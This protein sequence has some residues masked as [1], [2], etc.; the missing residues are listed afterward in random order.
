MKLEYTNWE[1]Y[2]ELCNLYTKVVE[3]QMVPEISLMYIVHILM[4][5][6]VVDN[7]LGRHHLQLQNGQGVPVPA[8]RT[9]CEQTIVMRSIFPI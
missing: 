1:T 6:I 4:M 8:V 9:G 3:C 5:Q 2:T 7:F